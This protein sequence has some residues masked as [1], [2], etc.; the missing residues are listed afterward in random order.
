MPL[1]AK[2]SNSLV[3]A[4]YI[5]KIY[6]QSTHRQQQLLLPTMVPSSGEVYKDYFDNKTL[7]DLALRIGDRLIHVHR[8][9]LSSNSAYFNK[10]FTGG[11]KVRDCWLC[12]YRTLANYSDRKPTRKRSSSMKTILQR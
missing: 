1:P 2:S 3:F 12:L 4:Y 11:F 7:F 8:I 6:F 10:L 5:Q 9:V